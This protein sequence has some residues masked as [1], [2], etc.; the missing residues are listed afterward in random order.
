MLN[1]GMMTQ[2]GLGTTTFKHTVRLCGRN[3]KFNRTQM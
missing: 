2:T 1:H 3:N